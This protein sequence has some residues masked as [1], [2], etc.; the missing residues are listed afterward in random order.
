MPNTI[1]PSLV[2]CLAVLKASLVRG[3]H[4]HHIQGRA[5]NG[6]AYAKQCQGVSG[7]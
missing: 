3:D 6:D 2:L 1:Q 5:S 7:Y 4:L